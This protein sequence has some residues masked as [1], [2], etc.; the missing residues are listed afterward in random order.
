[1]IQDHLHTVDPMERD[2]VM[3]NN[4]SIVHS[5]LFGFNL[6]NAYNTDKNCNIFTLEQDEV[7]NNPEYQQWSSTN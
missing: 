5:N 3:E 6:N 7:K 4:V 1:M 2:Q